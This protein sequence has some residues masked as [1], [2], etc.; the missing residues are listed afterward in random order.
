[1]GKAYQEIDASIARFV[2]RQ[3]LFFV[4]TAPLA[5]DG[6]VNCSPKGLDSLR[7][8]DSKTLVYADVGG[9]G[10]NAVDVNDLVKENDAV[11]FAT[12]GFGRM[13]KTTS[14][15]YANTGDG[16]AVLLRRGVPLEDMEFFQ[17]HPT[18]IAGKG[19][20]LSEGARGEGGGGGP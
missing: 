12:G 14:N 3:K 20:L 10:D 18:G 15:A 7:I 6:L 19:M 17:F 16:L 13:F 8:L 4:A 2:Q 9:S 11:L 1:M 5:G